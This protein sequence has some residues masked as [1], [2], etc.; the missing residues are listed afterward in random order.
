M[1]AADA[2]PARKTHRSRKGAISARTR[3]PAAPA[4]PA[5]VGVKMP[6][7][8]PAMMPSTRTAMP[9]MPTVALTRSMNGGA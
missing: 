5:S 9:T 3:A 6:V 8:I 4:A 7:Y 2:V 1:V